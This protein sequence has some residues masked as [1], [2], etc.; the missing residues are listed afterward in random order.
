MEEVA[1]YVAGL[2]LLLTLM[3]LAVIKFSKANR[4]ANEMISSNQSGQAGLGG[5]HDFTSRI[6]VSGG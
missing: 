5:P 3:L 4:S 1:V 6:R 2:I